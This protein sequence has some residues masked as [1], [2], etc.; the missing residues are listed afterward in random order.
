[1]VILRFFGEDSSNDK[2]MC[3]NMILIFAK[4]VCLKFFIGKTDIFLS[5]SC[6]QENA[7]N[8]KY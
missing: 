7:Q 4:A 6:F 3:C 5:A 2:A 8:I 1:M